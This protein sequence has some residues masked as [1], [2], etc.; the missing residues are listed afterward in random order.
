MKNRQ[1]SLQNKSKVGTK[2]VVVDMN[3]FFNEGDL[4]D[5]E[6]SHKSDI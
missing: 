3:K 4:Q 1:D 6:I 2:I 5:R